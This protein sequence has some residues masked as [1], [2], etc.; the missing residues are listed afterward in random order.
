MMRLCYNANMSAPK[1]REVVS[2]F[3]LEPRA[4][5][6]VPDSFRHRVLAD[7]NV[8]NAFQK[9]TGEGFDEDLLWWHLWGLA[10]LK[11]ATQNRKSRWYAVSGLA[12]YALRRFP[13]R[14]RSMANEIER[15][16]GKIQSN[17]TYRLTSQLLPLFLAGT[18]PG[19]EIE[20]HD[21]GDVIREV[22]T[23]SRAIPAAL[24]R[25]LLHRQADLRKLVELP[26]L[27]RLY[28]D[29]LEALRKLVG[30]NAPEAAALV[31]GMMPLQLIR[32]T[33]DLT[34]R[35][36]FSQIATLLEAA[37]FALGID[38]IVDPH[39]LQMQYRRLVSRKR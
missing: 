32:D 9:L 27:L 34:G 29:Y 3:W 22:G 16:D 18:I 36:F 21:S 39:N 20:V 13:K 12:P 37:Y 15:V 6:R 28:A 10:S 24:A 7:P 23:A 4:A 17:T 31:K 11:K 5:Q 26:N 8:K 2:T 38:E 25:R 14:I 35:P 30:H 33:K 19:A 1:R